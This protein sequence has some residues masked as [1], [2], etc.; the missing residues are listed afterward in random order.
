MGGRKEAYLYC[1]GSAGLMKVGGEVAGKWVS[2]WDRSLLR[3]TWLAPE[4]STSKED[5][6]VKGG[7]EIFF[8]K[9]FFI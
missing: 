1:S 9:Q 5:G 6:W 2:P 3:E 4:D 8:Q 7:N